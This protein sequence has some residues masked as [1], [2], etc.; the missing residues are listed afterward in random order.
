MAEHEAHVAP[1]AEPQD[2]L[3]AA[4]QCAVCRKALCEPITLPCQHTFCRACLLRGLAAH[5]P[6]QRCALCAKQGLELTDVLTSNET[7]ALRALLVELHGG[8][9]AYAKRVAANRIEHADLALKL[10]DR[11]QEQHV[12]ARP[13]FY[14]PAFPVAAPP[15]A[16]Q[17]VALIVGAAAIGAVTALLCATVLIWRQDIGETSKTNLSI[18]LWALS[19]GGAFIAWLQRPR[20]P[21]Y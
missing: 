5:N 18:S 4:L 15:V 12:R 10:W 21:K 16:P 2:D 1:I 13:V 11:L 3:E 19:A 9:A 20:F 7:F 14:E 8:D 6:Q 17:R